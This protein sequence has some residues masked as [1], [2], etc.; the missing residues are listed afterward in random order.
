MLIG[1]LA[2]KS[3]VSRDTIRY[4]EKLGLIRH[5]FRHENGY[6]IYNENTV[7]VVRFIRICQSLGFTLNE[8]K[9]YL[10]DIFERNF[11][12]GQV[13]AIIEKKIEEILGR[14]DQLREMSNSLKRILNSCS[15]S[16]SIRD[17]LFNYQDPKS[18]DDTLPN[19]G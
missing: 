16:D 1:E 15:K 6:R 5:G 7:F 17:S 4:Y 12:Y 19:A 10:A 11:S 13:E 18:E 2:E 9:T 3:N 8:I 14:I